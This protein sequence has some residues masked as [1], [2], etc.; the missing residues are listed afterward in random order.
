LADKDIALM[1]PKDGNNKII[2]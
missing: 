2:K 1:M